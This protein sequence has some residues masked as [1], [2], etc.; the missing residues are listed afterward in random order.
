MS[1]VQ[2]HRSWDRVANVFGESTPHPRGSVW[3]AR[4]DQ[5]LDEGLTDR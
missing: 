4:V 3:P 2:N 5:S 1:Q